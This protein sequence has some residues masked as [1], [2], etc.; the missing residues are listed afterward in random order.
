MGEFVIICPMYHTQIQPIA[1]HL[2]L[3]S[4]HILFYFKMVTLEH[5]VRASNDN[6]FKQIQQISRYNYKTFL[7]EP[8]II[9]DFLTMCL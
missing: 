1:G 3:T 7:D 2:F 4:C 9:E 6:L 8:D 5:S